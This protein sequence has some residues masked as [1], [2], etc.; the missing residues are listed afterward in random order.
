MQLMQLHV[1]AASQ[2]RADGSCTHVTCI[3]FL[4]LCHSTV[5]MIEAPSTGKLRR[6]AV[7]ARYM[8]AA[9]HDACQHQA[10]ALMAHGVQRVR[11][12][13]HVCMWF[14]RPHEWLAV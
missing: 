13:R 1:A 7:S 2:Q 12:V 11:L 5:C 6:D 3:I 8:H 4:H 9:V 10:S 14:T